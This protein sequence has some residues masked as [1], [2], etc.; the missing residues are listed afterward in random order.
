MPTAVS[1]PAEMLAFLSE[2]GFLAAPQ[3]QQ[4]SGK[5][6]D[7]QA[8]ARELVGRNWLTP[9][10]ANQLLA[11]RG[12]DL[13][14]GSYRILDRLGEGGMGQIFK[15]HH[16]SMDRTIALK[17]IPKDRMS[18]PT[19]VSRFQR[20]VRAVAKLSHPNIVIA[21]EVNQVGHTPFLAMEYVEGIDLAR[22]VQ[23]SGPLSIPRAC[24]YIRQAA[25]GLQHAHERGL[26]HRDIKPGNLMVTR[27]D[28]NGPPVIKI[29]DFG[30]AR[31]ESDS[32]NAARLT[33]LG[34]IVGTV[35][36]MAPEQAQ[37]P[38]TADIR[39]DIYSLGC[40]LFYLLT[41]KPPFPGEDA[42][43]KISARV[44]GDASSVRQVRPEV[45]PALERVIAKMMARNAGDRNQTPGEVAKAL[46]PYSHASSAVDRSVVLAQISAPR[47]A[48]IG[49]LQHGDERKPRGKTI[50]PVGL[51]LAGVVALVVV[52]AGLIVLVANNGG[53][54]SKPQVVADDPQEKNK[55]SKLS[56]LALNPLV[57]F[58]WIDD[59][60]PAGAVLG[61]EPGSL[62]WG[63][64]PTHRVS[65][66]TKSMKR[67]GEGIH[68]HL[69][70]GASPLTIQTRDMLFA[71][72]WIDPQNPPKTVGLQ[73][74]SGGWDH[75]AY[76]GIDLC[77]MPGQREGPDHHYKGLLPPPGKWTRLE[78]V[79][80]EI[81]L[82]PGSQITG[83]AFTQFGGTAFY[84]KVG[85][86]TSTPPAV[87]KKTPIRPSELR[88]V[89]CVDGRDEL[90]ITQTE[91]R[92]NHHAWGP[93]TQVKVGSVEWDT[94][95]TPIMDS[96]G[97]AQLIGRHVDDLSKAKM[98]KI[99]G[100]GPV[101]FEAN[102]DF[103]AVV[104]DDGGPPGADTYEVLL[105]FG[106]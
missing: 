25:I 96:V 80:E 13:F 85:V 103:I 38:R 63:K 39:A 101:S 28:P 106:Q 30:L 15:A 57:D 9:Y 89:A 17:I 72:V 26:V 99:R 3:V 90:R 58:V 76:W 16:V 47:W 61:G 86:R 81:G 105:S 34:K 95:K 44:L 68:Q 40:S 102:K 66:G 18:D 1:S 83:I 70:E 35:D 41:G 74:L 59:A 100:R 55:Q 73:F 50:S 14:L 11:G 6:P 53:S 45:S 24:E 104:F 91:T 10:Q 94:Q 7:A 69:F 12:D 84:D 33:Q 97:I 4:L 43:E 51:L 98:K 21:F 64:E 32:A 56:D 31:F 27:R 42:V 82:K 88:V 29:L 36:F 75:R 8:L 2:Y 48:E 49:S 67:S 65:S 71:H 79:P 92:W 78:V 77:F 46:E 60:P 19:A 93:P 87:A 37:D 52:L 23:Q 20:E 54:D 22:L 62:L 5:H